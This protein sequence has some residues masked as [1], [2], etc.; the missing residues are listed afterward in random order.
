[1]QKNLKHLLPE[2]KKTNKD[3]RDCIKGLSGQLGEAPTSQTI[4]HQKE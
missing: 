1:M 2:S 3:Y 4:E